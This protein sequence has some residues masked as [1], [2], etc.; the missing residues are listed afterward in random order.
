VIVHIILVN[1]T[2]GTGWISAM[3]RFLAWFQHK[4]DL[5]GMSR[6]VFKILIIHELF[7]GVWGTIITVVLAGLFPT[8]LATATDIIFLPILLALSSILIRI[9]TIALFWYTWGKIRAGL[10][11]VLGFVMAVSGFG[12]PFG[13]R[14]IFAEVTY[15]YALG[16]AMQGMKD[17]ARIAVFFNPLYPW[18]LL[19]TWFGAL[20]IGGFI[21][22]SFFA[23]KGNV[24]PKFACTG[25]WHGALFL[26]VQ[27]VLGPSYLIN[28]GSK[29]PLLYSNILG[30][31]GS[32]FDVAPLFALKLLLIALLVLVSIKVWTKVKRGYGIVPRYALVLGPVAIMVALI[33]EFMN[34]GGKYPYLILLGNTGLSPSQFMNLYVEIPWLVMLAIVG[35]LL[36]F[37]G[38]F[39]VTA[40]Y[41]LNRGFLPDMPQQF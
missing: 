36:A 35:V 13:F 6:K 26:T 15:P 27:G 1:I 22:A 20:S 38:A 8:L 28:L 14:Y 18:L 33:G 29:A 17:I 21:V 4:P 3:A 2:L 37:V 34:D 41:A 30:Q 23:I 39:M 10:H 11:T 40:Y 25:L 24:N 31:A 5:E 12:V 19:H 16:M 9:P 7:S 32:T